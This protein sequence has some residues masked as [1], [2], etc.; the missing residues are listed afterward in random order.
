MIS[1]YLFHPIYLIPPLPYFPDPI[2]KKLGRP[3]E[4]FHHRRCS[5]YRSLLSSSS[6]FSLPP[7]MNHQLIQLPPLQLMILPLSRKKDACT[8]KRSQRCGRS[9]H[10]WT[11]G[12][13]GARGSILSTPAWSILLKFPSS[14]SKFPFFSPESCAVYSKTLTRPASLLQ[15]PFQMQCICALV[16]Q[17]WSA[18]FL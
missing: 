4:C 15:L 8:C 18:H 16:Y 14:L 6:S 2:T 1:L 7:L 11:T 13:T 12:V 3:Q 17:W 5:S 9:S 10:G